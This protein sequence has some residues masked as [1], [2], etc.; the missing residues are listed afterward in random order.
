MPRLHTHSESVSPAFEDRVR[1]ELKQ[2]ATIQSMTTRRGLK[3]E[4]GSDILKRRSRLRFALFLTAVAAAT[5]VVALALPLRHSTL[6]I[7]SPGASP[8][9]SPLG[10]GTA[11]S[12]TTTLG[13]APPPPSSSRPTTVAPT[14]TSVGGPEQYVVKRGDTLQSIA[15]AHGTTREAIAELNQWP[16]GINQP[17]IQGMTILIQ[18][19]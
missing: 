7:G 1:R 6:H 12:E 4:H 19:G 10:S 13:G 11:S 2:V 14:S 9:A 8:S 18:E 16:T 15:D 17:L 3:P 5:V